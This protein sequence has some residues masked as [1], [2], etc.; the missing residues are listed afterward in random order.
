MELEEQRRKAADFAFSIF[1]FGDLMVSETGAW[2]TDDPE[3]MTR[4]VVAESQDG[5]KVEINFH[6]RFDCLSAEAQESYGLN[7]KSGEMI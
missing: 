7:R 3:D 5:E 4:T 1:D 2:N 6:V